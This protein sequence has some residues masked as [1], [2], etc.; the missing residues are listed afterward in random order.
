MLYRLFLLVLLL[1]VGVWVAGCSASSAVASDPNPAPQPLDAPKTDGPKTG[2]APAPVEAP[3]TSEAPKPAEPPKT[4]EAPKPPPLSPACQRLLEQIR[5]LE[6]G[7]PVIFQNLKR[8]V[9]EIYDDILACA[10]LCRKFL[11]ECPGIEAACEVKATL[12]RMELAGLSHK[13][14]EIDRSRQELTAEARAQLFREHVEGLL[15]QAKEAAADC[16]AGSKP[17]STAKRCIFDLYARL[18]EHEKAT[19][20]AEDLLKEFPDYELRSSVQTSVATSLMTLR[21]YREAADYLRKVIKEHSAEPAL[22]LFQDKLLDALLGVGDLE[23]VEEL[24]HLIRAEYPERMQQIKEDHYLY[25]QYE[26]WM[27]M[28]LF[29]LGFVRMALGDND[30]ALETFK[31]HI[32]EYEDRV[33]K[34]QEK[35]KNVGSNDICTITVE[36]RS[37]DMIEV[38]ENFYPITPTRCFE[39]EDM[40]ATE[41]RLEWSK[42]RGKVIGAMFRQPGDMRAA[43]FLQELDTLVKERRKDG[44]VGI[45]LTHTAGRRDPVADGSLRERIRQDL[46]SLGVTLPA[47]ADPDHEGQKLFREVHATVG[48]ASFVLFGRDGKMI[49]FLADPRD[50]DRGVL[51]RV[52]DR[53]LAEGKDAKK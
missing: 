6:A 48:T 33:R 22:V 52:I 44:L 25:N 7:V 37:R 31:Q 5:A 17:R 32:A 19:A 24:I 40:W 51:R 13:Q 30:G 42:L 18:G 36:Y 49:W 16:P 38:L 27:C 12:V 28:S 8:P 29:W 20:A 34:L 23:G 2:P 14:M 47:G 35:G 41:E 15:R 50:I 4:V 53:V 21:R 43:S 39:L 26:Q 46:K 1:S 45:T 9:K 3:K 10:E 11:A